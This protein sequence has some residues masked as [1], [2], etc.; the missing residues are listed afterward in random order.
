MSYNLDVD[1]NSA[2][3]YD[4]NT[5]SIVCGLL[6]YSYAKDGEKLQSVY[7]S[8]I[9]IA[10]GESYFLSFLQVGTKIDLSSGRYGIAYRIKYNDLDYLAKTDSLGSEVS[11]LS[12]QSAW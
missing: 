12:W 5:G 3:V 7:N 11:L 2:C 8:H 1:L 6:A 4:T 10:P 9:V